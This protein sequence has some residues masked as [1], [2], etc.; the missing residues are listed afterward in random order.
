MHGY[1]LASTIG[2]F[3]LML[4]LLITIG[5]AIHS[6]R[7]GRKATP[8]P[9]RANTLEWFSTSPPPEHDFDVIPIVRSA[10]PMQDIRRRA[11]QVEQQLLEDQTAAPVS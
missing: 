2:S 6:V 9:W 3:V 10:E 7:R 11:A 5:N 1:N 4:G 8:D